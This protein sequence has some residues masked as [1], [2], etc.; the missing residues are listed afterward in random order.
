MQTQPPWL[1]RTRA[2]ATLEQ[3]Q[4]FQV[5]RGGSSRQARRGRL[6]GRRGAIPVVSA[7]VVH[8]ALQVGQRDANVEGRGLGARVGGGHLVVVRKDRRHD[9]FQGEGRGAVVLVSPS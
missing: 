5:R 8:E 6:R 3:Q 7:G 4:R 1:N 2:T 9:V